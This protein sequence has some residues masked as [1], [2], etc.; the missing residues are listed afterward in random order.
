M[1]GL[2]LDDAAGD[3]VSGVAGGV[4]HEVVGFGVDDQGGATVVEEGVGFVAEGDSGE[5]EAGFGLALFIC[6]EVGDVAEVGVGRLRIV[7]AMMG[8][9][10][11]EGG[12]G[13]GKVRPVALAF[14]VDVDAVF[15]GG[16]VLDLDRGPDALGSGFK[17]GGA[18]FCV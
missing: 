7:F 5:Q 1:L 2:F 15:A 14:V 11:V 8:T 10:L 3:A 4:G 9:G 13:G 16:D 18:D 17:F 12:C 6:G